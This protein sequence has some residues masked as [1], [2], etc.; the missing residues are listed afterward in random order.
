MNISDY[1]EY[2]GDTNDCGPYSATIAA[3]ALAGY[4]RYNPA[5]V[6]EEMRFRFPQGATPPWA[7]VWWLRQQGLDTYTRVWSDYGHMW[8][9]LGRNQIP[10]VMVGAWWPF[11]LHWKVIS[12]A[13]DRRVFSVDPGIT[14]A[15]VSEEYSDFTEVWKPFGCVMIEVSR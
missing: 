10:I 5:E 1:H 6:A 9:A 11:W 14:A 13:T 2:Q 4:R 3:N 15:E 12:K 8:T 7:I